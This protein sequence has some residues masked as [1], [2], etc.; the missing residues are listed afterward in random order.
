MSAKC[1]FEAKFTM[2]QV[3]KNDWIVISGK[4]YDV[5]AFKNEHP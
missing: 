1:T 4:V 2:D 3:L 5:R